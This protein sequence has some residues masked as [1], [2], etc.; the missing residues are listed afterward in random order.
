MGR[1]EGAGRE[2]GGFE[3][4]AM[5]QNKLNKELKNLRADPIPQV[6]IQTEHGARMSARERAHSPARQRRA[7]VRG[8]RRS[9]LAGV[10]GRASGW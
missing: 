5:A 9:A 10:H 8:M 7:S 4:V 3:S 1:R 6:S 2:L